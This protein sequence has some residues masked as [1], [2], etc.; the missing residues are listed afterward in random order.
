MRKFILILC[1]LVPNLAIAD[2]YSNGY[3]RLD[4][5]YVQGYY[6]SSP[7]PTVQNNYSYKGNEN[8][9]TGQIGSNYYRNNT[10]SA[11]YAPNPPTSSQTLSI[12]TRWGGV[13]NGINNIANYYAIREM[14]K[15]QSINNCINYCE[16]TVNDPQ[17]CPNACKIYAQKYFSN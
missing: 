12:P 10:T 13:A 6:R 17:D 9:Y 3:L 16:N 4:G 1:V 11:Y 5:A 8:P 2:E 15:Q 7:D 14:Q